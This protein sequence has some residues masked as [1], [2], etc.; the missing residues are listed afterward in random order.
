[1]AN[2]I[3]ATAVDALGDAVLLLTPLIRNPALSD[4]VRVMLVTI[5]H[6]L[7]DLQDTI[8]GSESAAPVGAPLH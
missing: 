1:M 4:E 8:I 7:C 3:E 5:T 6:V 2:A